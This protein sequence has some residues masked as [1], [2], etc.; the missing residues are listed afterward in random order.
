MAMKQSISAAPLE[1][2]N[3]LAYGCA[4]GASLLR[5][6]DLGLIEELMNETGTRGRPTR[7]QRISPLRAAHQVISRKPGKRGAASGLWDALRDRPSATA[8]R[9]GGSNARLH[10][11]CYWLLKLISS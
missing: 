11:N 5:S 7:A 10:G 4:P 3:D 1:L 9:L 2:L 8:V 6:Q